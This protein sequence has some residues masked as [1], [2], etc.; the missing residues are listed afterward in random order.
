MEYEYYE[1]FSLTFQVLTFLIVT[2]WITFSLCNRRARNIQIEIISE[3]NIQTKRTE[4]NYQILVKKSVQPRTDTQTQ[5]RT[6]SVWFE[7]EEEDNTEPL[8]HH[9]SVHNKLYSSLP[10]L[11]TSLPQPPFYSGYLPSAP[12]P[13]AVENKY[14]ETFLSSTSEEE[15][16]GPTLG[17]ENIVH[18]TEDIQ[19]FINEVLID[20]ISRIEKRLKKSNM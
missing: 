4:N 2:C 9:S 17:T 12:E 1:A 6:R 16:R 18:N 15:H 19:S 14:K 10:A 3:E 13:E 7:G 11:G 8:L 20:R 5:T